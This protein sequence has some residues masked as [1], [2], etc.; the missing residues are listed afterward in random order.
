MSKNS[1][2]ARFI[3]SLLPDAI[4]GGGYTHHTLLAFNAA[5]LHDFIVHSKTLDEG[6]LAFLLSALLEP[7]LSRSSEVESSPKDS[8]VSSIPRLLLLYL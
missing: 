8:I 7:L 6:T 1:D 4:R 5:C 3:T 2:V